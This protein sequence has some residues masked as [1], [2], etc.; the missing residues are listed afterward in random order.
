M[1][2]KPPDAAATAELVA[3][4]T[5]ESSE[6]V[7][8]LI[9]LSKAQV[10][11]V[12]RDASGDGSKSGPDHQGVIGGDEVAIGTVPSLGEGGSDIALFIRTGATPG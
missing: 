11:R 9:A 4:T 1:D 6:R 10:D 7:P 3:S 5:R 2:G 8:V 12:V